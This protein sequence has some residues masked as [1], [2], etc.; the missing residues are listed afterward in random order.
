MTQLLVRATMCP[1]YGIA[2]L[3]VLNGRYTPSGH[4]LLVSGDSIIDVGTPADLLRTQSAHSYMALS[5]TSSPCTTV[6]VSALRKSG[7]LWLI[8]RSRIQWSASGKVGW[9]PIHERTIWR[10]IL[11]IW[12]FS[13]SF[14]IHSTLSREYQWLDV[15][16]TLSCF[17]R[18]IYMAWYY[19]YVASSAFVF[20]YVECIPVLQTMIIQ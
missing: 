11:C 16:E 14:W 9:S 5:R 15:W 4:I 12:Y 13:C 2:L 7:P 8:L 19:M 1:T 6:Q 20:T 18:T 10:A 3:T 17:H